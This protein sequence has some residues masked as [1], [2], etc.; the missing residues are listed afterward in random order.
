ML[1]SSKP[2]ITNGAAKIVDAS[3]ISVG[4]YVTVLITVPSGAANSVYLGGPNVTT[5][6]GYPIA[7]GAT[8]GFDKLGPGDD[9]WL[10][11]PANTDVNVLVAGL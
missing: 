8:W 3:K 1:K 5:G 10:V 11:A 7:A 6:N 2:T 4:D 9:V